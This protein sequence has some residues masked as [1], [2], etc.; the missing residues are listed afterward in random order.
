MES[1]IRVSYNNGEQDRVTASGR[2]STTAA[3]LPLDGD[4]ASSGLNKN[5]EAE[6]QT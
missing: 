5:M 4:V 1:I 2:E 3:L 6:N